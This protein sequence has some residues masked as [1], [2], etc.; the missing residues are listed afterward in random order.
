[1][2]YPIKQSDWVGGFDGIGQ[3][4]GLH[5][6]PKEEFTDVSEIEDLEFGETYIV[7]AEYK[8]LADFEGKVRK[9]NR[10]KT[11]NMKY[12]SLLCEDSSLIVQSIK[13]DH[14]NEYEKYLKCVN[15]QDRGEWIDI[16]IC[17]PDKQIDVLE[18]MFSNVHSSLCAPFIYPEY[19]LAL[20]G[21]GLSGAPHELNMPDAQKERYMVVSLFNE[22]FKVKD[23]RMVFTRANL[24]IIDRRA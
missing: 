19:C 24:T 8:I 9:R 12:C 14:P 13:T 10:F 11:C 23:K 5:A 16:Y 1:M 2:E 15:K 17:L 20:N 3:I 22:N 7:V 21:E 6:L 4:I 18:R